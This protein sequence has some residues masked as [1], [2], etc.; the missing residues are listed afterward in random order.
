MIKIS[1]CAR[2]HTLRRRSHIMISQT[3]TFRTARI[4]QSTFMD[5]RRLSLKLTT[6]HRLSHQNLRQVCLPIITTMMIS[7][8]AFAASLRCSKIGT[9]HLIRR[10]RLRSKHFPKPFQALTLGRTDRHST[11]FITQEVIRLNSLEQSLALPKDSKRKVKLFFKSRP[12]LVVI[13]L[14]KHKSC[15]SKLRPP[16]HEVQ[17][18]P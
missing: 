1:T 4:H 17:I 8:K 16:W 7:L 13:P 2:Q 5:S 6:T 12:Y 15:N 18:K 9:N 14:Q 11:N 10:N 3:L